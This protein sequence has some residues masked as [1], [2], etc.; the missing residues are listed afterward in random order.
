MSKELYDSWEEYYF[1][2]WLKELQEA[3]YIKE[4]EYHPPALTL[5][6]PVDYM[7]KRVLHR[8]RVANNTLIDAKTLM[9]EHTYQYDWKITWAPKAEGILYC[10]LDGFIENLSIFFAE[11]RNSEIVSYID[12]KGSFSNSSLDTRFPLNQKWVFQKYGIYVQKVVL[13]KSVKKGVRKVYSGLFPDT[14]VP[15][16]YLMTDAQKQK[17]LIHF[18]YILLNDFINKQI[19][20]K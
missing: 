3:G 19:V 1:S 7:V 5:A 17:R 8:K 2:E 12:I 20:S 15:E 10:R 9:R 11:E 18:K 4:T 14:F 6:E 16:R 13:V